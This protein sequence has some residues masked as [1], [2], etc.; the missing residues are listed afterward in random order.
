MK[1]LI[2]VCEGETEQQ[3]CEELLRNHLFNKDI[4]MFTPIIKK[5]NGGICTWSVLKKQLKCH[6]N[7]GQAYGAELAKSIGLYEIREKCPHF[8][9]W[10]TTIE[11][12]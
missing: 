5:T 3:F 7:E 9:E 11:A 1:R 10:L 6:L 4:L 12:L 8:N 2:I